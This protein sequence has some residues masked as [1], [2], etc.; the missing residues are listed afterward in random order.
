MNQNSLTKRLLAALVLL[1]V[2]CNGMSA[3]LK[4]FANRLMAPQLPLAGRCTLLD[5]LVQGG[6]ALS[7]KENSIE[8]G[9]P[10]NQFQL[11]SY[12]EMVKGL[13]FNTLLYCVQGLRAVAGSLTGGESASGLVSRTIVGM[14]VIAAA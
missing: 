7:V 8:V 2:S 4:L 1:V 13:Q 6:A 14:T 10:Q 11:H 12:L 5:V 9:N 3:G